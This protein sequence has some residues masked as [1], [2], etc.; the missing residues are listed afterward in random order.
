LITKNVIQEGAE[1]AARQKDQP[2]K[3]LGKIELNFY[4][5]V[6]YFNIL[7]DGSFEEGSGKEQEGKLIEQEEKNEGAIL[8]KV[9]REYMKSAGIRFVFLALFLFMVETLGLV[10]TDMYDLNCNL[11]SKQKIFFSQLALTLGS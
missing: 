3:N 8:V 4:L 5:H 7:L 1:G 2:S 6:D 10:G 11:L 9:Y